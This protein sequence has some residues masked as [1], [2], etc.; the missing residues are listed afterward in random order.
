MRVS[1]H[2]E[3]YFLN[4]IPTRQLVPG[5]PTK[6]WKKRKAPG[7]NCASGRCQV[8]ILSC[9]TWHMGLESKHVLPSLHLIRTSRSVVVFLFHVETGLC[10]RWWEGIGH[11]FNL[12]NQ[13]VIMNG[14]PGQAGSNRLM[15]NPEDVS[16]ARAAARRGLLENIK[17]KTPRAR[18]LPAQLVLH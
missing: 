12:W 7:I 18:V 15:T 2:G 16:R 6:V 3:P 5:R 8:F 14:C 4:P 17:W 11:L 9:W 10:M 13:H 1:C